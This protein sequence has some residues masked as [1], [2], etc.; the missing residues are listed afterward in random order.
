MTLAP[1]M[2]P[3]RR[4]LARHLQRLHGRPLDGVE[5]EIELG[6]ALGSY[7]RY[8]LDAFRLPGKTPAELE[9]GIAYEGIE[10]LM[11]ASAGGKGVVMAM[12]HLG[13]WEW[14]G[15]WLASIGYPLTVVVEALDPPEL[16]DWFEA[17]R[18]DMGLRVIK[19]GPEAAGGLLD[20]LRQGGVVGLLSDRD[21]AGNGV[22]VTFFGERTTLPA[23]PATLAVRT[24]APLLP[25]AVLFE[26]AG[27]RGI[28]RPPIDTTRRGGLRA[29]I[30]R[31]T[32]DLA[33]ELESLIQ[34]APEQWHVLVPNWPSDPGYA[35][36]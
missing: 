29:D 24:G 34:R 17:L 2:G 36:R 31:I 8:W 4:T 14:G 33:F 13:A 30:T 20:T 7:A 6:R 35:R 23:G 26:G 18:R 27:H 21:V 12:P 3:K 32:Q 9:A 10:H 22:E 16:F 5:L 1:F 28:V 19:L 11:T 15:S 25:C